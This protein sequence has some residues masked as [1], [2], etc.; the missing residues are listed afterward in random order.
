[1]IEYQRKAFVAKENS[2]RVTLD[3]NVRVSESHF[4]LFDEHPALY[5]AMSPFH[6]IM[7]V[8]YQG[9]LLDYIQDIINQ[10]QGTEV[11][12]GKYMMSR[13]V[14]KKGGIIW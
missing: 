10:V 5:P 9:F 2:T 13:S 6:V 1:M 3:S 8:K 14:S 4:D 7:E 11:A 12:V